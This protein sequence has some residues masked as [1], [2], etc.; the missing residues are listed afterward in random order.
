MGQELIPG[1]PKQSGQTTFQSDPQNHS[2]LR[3][4]DDKS[5]HLEGSCLG[6]KVGCCCEAFSP[7]I[8][9]DVVSGSN[10]HHMP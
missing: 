4:E 7:H 2:S 6:S 10:N 9:S 8:L 1:E 3:K 5:A